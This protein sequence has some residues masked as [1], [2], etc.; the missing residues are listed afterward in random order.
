MK[1]TTAEATRVF[2]LWRQDGHFYSGTV[3]IL[4]PDN[5]F[6]VKFDDGTEAVA[7]VEQMRL[8]EFRVGDDVLLPMRTRSSKVVGLSKVG[9]DV[10][11]VDTDGDTEE[12]EIMNIRIASRTIKS[13]WKDRTLAI[14]DVVPA[15]PPIKTN[16]SPAPSGAS[17][18]SAHSNKS[19]RKKLLSKTGLVVSLS[20]GNANREKEKESLIS[21]IKNNGGVVLDDWTSVVRMEG[22]HTVNNNRW[23]LN[24]D[25]V[26]WNG[27]EEIDRVF[28]LADDSSQKPKFLMAIG[29]GIPCLSV[30]WL[31]D[32]IS[33]VSTQSKLRHC[34]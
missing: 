9:D 18:A 2:A 30:N 22:K 16:G 31:H 10:V 21:T 32:S 4:Q 15:V 3:H 23:V 24:R 14:E 13:A 8:R 17:L 28:L 6:L 27:K 11:I 29:L 1:S 5:R 20:V 25:E 19:A 33:T 7:S 34:N 26:Q 12:V